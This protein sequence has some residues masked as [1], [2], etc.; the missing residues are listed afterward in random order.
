LRDHAYVFRV[1]MMGLDR[2]SGW[3]RREQDIAAIRLQ[4]ECVESTGELW[5]AENERREVAHVISMRP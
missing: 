4:F 5:K 3:V 1:V 2:C